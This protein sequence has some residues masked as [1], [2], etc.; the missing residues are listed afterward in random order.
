MG[1]SLILQGGAKL[2]LADDIDDLSNYFGY[3]IRIA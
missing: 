3:A 2:K 1:S